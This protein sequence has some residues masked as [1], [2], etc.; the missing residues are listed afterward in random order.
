MTRIE[1]INITDHSKLINAVFN[2]LLSSMQLGIQLKSTDIHKM[3][4][5]SF[6]DPKNDLMIN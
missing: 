2:I 5:Q 3:M 1:D 6:P 4:E